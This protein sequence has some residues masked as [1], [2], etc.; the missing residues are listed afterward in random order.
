MDYEGTCFGKWNE[1]H[2]EMK[3]SWI[4]PIIMSFDIAMLKLTNKS[5]VT[6]T[7][8]IENSPFLPVIQKEADELGKPHGFKSYAISSV[9]FVVLSPQAVLLTADIIFFKS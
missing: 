2:P 1:Y 4:R 6:Y 8:T 5:M 7:T 9:S 3:V